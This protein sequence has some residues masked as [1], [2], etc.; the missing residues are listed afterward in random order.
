MYK[1]PV[2]FNWCGYMP[3]TLDATITDLIKLRSKLINKVFKWS[4]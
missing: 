4:L 2:S 1:M 3:L